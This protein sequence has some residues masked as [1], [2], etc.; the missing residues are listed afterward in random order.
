MSIGYGKLSDEVT[1][2]CDLKELIS[3]QQLASLAA[4]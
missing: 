2:V 3:Y 4:R 1:A